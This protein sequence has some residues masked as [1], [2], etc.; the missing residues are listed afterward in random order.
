MTYREKIV[1][2]SLLQIYYTAVYSLV[3]RVTSSVQIYLPNLHEIL[4]YF[5]S[6]D[7]SRPHILL[8]LITVITFGEEHSV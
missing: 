6:C 4:I 1:I 8:G 2:I 3:S 5:H 7:V